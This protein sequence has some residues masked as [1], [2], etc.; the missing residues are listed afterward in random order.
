MTVAGVAGKKPVN[1]SRKVVLVPDTSLE[2]VQN[3]DYDIVVMPGGLEG[4]NTFAASQVVGQILKRH[5]GNGKK[6]AAICAAPMALK[7][8]GIGVGKKVTCYPGID[9][10]LGDGYK[11]CDEKV[12]VDGN[13]ITSR[14][15]ATAF[16]FG[17][18]IVGNMVNKEKAS[19][20]AKAML[21]PGY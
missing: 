2:E 3:N 13:L 4:S 9:K 1:C 7:S 8:H 17:L 14:G 5:E 6:I 19:E 10:E 18:A 12:V 21:V 11:I 20:V 16:D 15:P